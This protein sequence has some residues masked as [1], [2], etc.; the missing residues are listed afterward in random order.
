[1]GHLGH[2]RQEYQDL[3]ERLEGGPVSLPM[4]SDP[5]ARA[6]WQEIL[7]ILFT[8]E[9]AALAAKLPVRPSSLA[10][11]A[12]LLGMTPEALRPRLD[13]MADKGLVLDLI[14]PETGKERWILAPPVVGFLEFSL[15]RASDSIPKDRM[16]RAMDAYVHGDDTFARELFGGETV[17]GR[18]LVQEDALGEGQAPTVVDWESATAILETATNIAVSLC[19]CR[20]MA[21]HV[22]RRCDAP[23]ENCLSLN[24]GADFVVR[25]GFGRK[26]GS[27]EALDILHAARDQGLVQIGDNIRDKPT[28]MC[29]CCGCCCGQLEVI[30]TLGFPAVN[31]S[32]FE[33]TADPDQCKGC[34]KCARACPIG[35][36]S[37]VAVRVEGQRKGR[38]VARVDRERCIGCGVC[39]NACRRKV[40]TMVPRPK[41]GYVPAT[42]M[43]RTLLMAIERGHLA[44]FVFDQGQSRGHRFLNH[45]LQALCNL[46]PAKR[47][48]AHG[49]LKSRFVSYALGKV[50]DPMG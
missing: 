42:L 37:L 34:G 40:M 1:M 29:N 47:A 17:I 6:A 22:G 4:P 19:Y 10:K 30:S 39:A 33:A 50:P 49:Q 20:H 36:V 16:S 26:V 31:P 25:R 5:T 14:H 8:P 41:R 13:A 28:Y 11:I 46:P 18:A 32:A 35:A 7:E 48:L 2:L 43:E 3:I 15:M 44:H 12:S 24:V 38:P 21:E 27:S 9:D 23:L 45:A